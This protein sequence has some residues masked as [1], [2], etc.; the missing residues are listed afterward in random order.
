[1][2]VTLPSI[3][4][5]S[6]GTHGSITGA[7]EVSTDDT[8]GMTI[9]GGNIQVA[10]AAI[11]KLALKQLC[12]SYL[13]A[14]VSSRLRGVRA[15]GARRRARGELRAAAARRSASTARSRSPCRP[16]TRPDFAA[17][18]GIASREFAYGGGFVDNAAIPL[19]AGNHARAR[20]LRPV[21]AD[22][23]CSSAATPASASPA[24]SCAA[25][26]R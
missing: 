14:N 16:P 9:D 1:M 2:Q 5:P 3:F 20:R 24:A 15:A 11:G 19:V 21:H 12:F 10:N 26:C 22:R 6:P 4:R 13:S 23:A 18:G 7:T 8:G 17:Y 25:T